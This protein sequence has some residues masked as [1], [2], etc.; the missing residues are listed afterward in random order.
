M[1]AGIFIAGF[2]RLDF[3]YVLFR[4]VALYLHIGSAVRAVQSEQVWCRRAPLESYQ[5]SLTRGSEGVGMSTV[6][7][8][9]DTNDRSVRVRRH[10]SYTAKGTLPESSVCRKS[11][12]ACHKG[13]W[14]W[15][16]GNG[17]TVLMSP[18]KQ[19]VFSQGDAAGAVFYIQAGQVKLTV[20]SQ[21]GKE[22]VVA[23]LERG[24]FFG[25]S[26][27]AG[28]AVRTATATAVED[29]R[30][31]R[32]DKEVMIRL[33]HE[34]PTFSELFLTH[35]LSRNL[36]IQDDLIDQLF[37][38]AEKRLARTLL[39]LAHSESECSK[40]SVMPKISQETLAEMIG[41]TR[42]RVSFFMKR[43]R[44]LGCIDYTHNR[45]LHVHR[46]LRTVVLDD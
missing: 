3:L 22:A 29:S 41:T 42:A 2:G 15:D 4:S 36:R 12:A 30:L 27:L 5:R 13:R 20:V 10:D 23:M 45:E 39:L 32:I 8:L 14:T 19:V 43:F 18:K 35:L 44:A 21:Q 24:A 6:H 7:L 33:L 16:P 17:R 38:S 34:E 40:E 28:Q 37:N 25:E 11:I 46:S 1:P 31:V 26:C 9:Q